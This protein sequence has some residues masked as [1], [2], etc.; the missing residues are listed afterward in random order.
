M[1]RFEFRLARLARVRRVEEEVAKAAWQTAVAIAREADER[2]AVIE[3]QL[4]EAY[5]FLRQAQSEGQ[6]HPRHVLNVRRST[7]LLEDHKRAARESSRRAHAEADEARVP[8]QKAHAALEGLSRLEDKARDRFR[9]ELNREEAKEAD[10]I[11]IQ[12][13]VRNARRSA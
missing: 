5:E 4:T 8:W 11:A 1:K 2:L 12:R 13:A 7:Q 10:Q 9:Q 3:T 6:L